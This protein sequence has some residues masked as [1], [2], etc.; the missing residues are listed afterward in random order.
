MMV[1][2]VALLSCGHILGAETSEAHI[3]VKGDKTA[4]CPVC[5]D[6]SEFDDVITS[7]KQ[8]GPDGR[9]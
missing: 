7:Q 2:W 8:A 3:P 9:R 5:H 6:V 4:F 1:R